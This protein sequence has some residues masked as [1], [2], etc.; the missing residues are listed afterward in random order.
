MARS[1]SSRPRTHERPLVAGVNELNA[2]AAA[3][4]ATRVAS[5]DEAALRLDVGENHNGSTDGLRDL[6]VVESYEA[7]W[8]QNPR[9]FMEQLVA[10]W[11]GQGWRGYSDYIGAPILIPG[12]SEQTAKE[13][14]TSDK[15]QDRIKSLAACRAEALFPQH[16]I[17]GQADE[18]RKKQ[19]QTVKTRTQ[20]ALEKQLTDVAKEQIRISI[21]RLDSMSFIKVFAASVNNILTR[22]YHQGIHINVP[23]VLELRRV[24]QIAAQR[25]QSIIFLPCHKSH[26]DYLTV[27]WLLFRLGISLP[28][29]VAGENLDLPIV[30]N[31]LRGGGAFFIRRTFSGDQL[32]PVVIREYIERLLINGRNMECFVEGTRSRTG[33]LLPPKLGI[34]KYIVEAVQSGRTDDVWICPISLQYD[35]V[36]ESETYVSELLGKPKESESLF[37][38]LSGSSSVLSLKL[39]RID[40]RFQ[41]PWSLKHFM[42]E[43]LE[44]RTE[45]L[46]KVVPQGSVTSLDFANNNEH[47]TLLLKALGYRVL[48]DINQTSVVMP[49]A[50]VGTVLLTLRGRGVGRALLERKVEWLRDAIVAKGYHVA[51]FGQMSTSDVVERALG[52]MKPLVDIHTDVLEETILPAKRFELSFFRNQVIHVFVNEALLC[53]ALYTK[54]KQGGTAPMQ[55]MARTAILAEC[56]YISGILRSEFVYGT[57]GAEV[58]VDR[59]IAGLIKSEILQEELDEATGDQAVGL[60][61]AER[62]RGRENYDTFLFLIW[63]FIESYWLACCAFLLLAPPQEQVSPA[64]EGGQGRILWFSA[65]DFEKK[66]QL[67]GKTLYDQGELAYLEAINS[68]TLSQAVTRFEELGLVMRRKSDSVK[69]IPLIALNPEYAPRY[70][71]QPIFGGEDAAGGKSSPGSTSVNGITLPEESGKLWDMLKHLSSFRR[72]GKER[73]ENLLG[74]RIMRHVMNDEPSVIEITT[75]KGQK[76]SQEGGQGARL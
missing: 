11:N 71:I 34:L 53:A 69:P 20:R 51:D 4:P 67:F 24:A 25:K 39:G 45:R 58:N 52:L 74:E 10:A 49:A 59:T 61:P 60:H 31:I 65:K 19:Y 23:Q 55:T 5:V 72:E 42:D 73:R 17:D 3:A 50:L 9:R 44:R 46:A 70:E 48:A 40:V 1:S 2:A 43:Q 6:N 12:Q 56:A 16:V 15:V 29:I 66:A 30:G 75:A 14:M 28:A 63:P 68:A 37:G 13:V 22:M 64:T 76:L 54:V 38:L 41:K 32:Y 62:A 27:S 8:R 47:K 7:H 33:K 35:S 26:I 18:Q 21:G 36:I 57:E